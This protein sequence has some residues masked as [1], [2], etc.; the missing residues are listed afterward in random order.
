MQNP[1]PGMVWLVLRR[2]WTDFNNFWWFVKLR[3]SSR[4]YADLE[5]V[6]VNTYTHFST[7]STIAKRKFHLASCQWNFRC[8]MVDLVLRGVSAFTK[9]PP[10][11]AYLRELGLSFTN[12]KKLSKSTRTKKLQLFQYSHKSNRN[13]SRFRIWCPPNVFQ[14]AAATMLA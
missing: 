10:K 14:W 3:P 7:I 9:T 5:G 1:F 2:Y 11:S 6:F 4:R 12:H 13:F 8:A